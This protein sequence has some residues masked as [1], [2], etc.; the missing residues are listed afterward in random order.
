MY[1]HLFYLYLYFFFA[2]AVKIRMELFGINLF[3]SHLLNLHENI[4]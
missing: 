3:D 2:Y 4:I 1:L